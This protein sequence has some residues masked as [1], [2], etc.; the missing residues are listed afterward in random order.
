ME[1]IDM[2]KILIIYDSD[3]GNDLILAEET[4]CIL[5]TLQAEVRI[6]RVS[7]VI[8]V[9][10]Q[11]HE[12]PDS[13]SVIAKEDVMWAEGYILAC[14]IHTGTFLEMEEPHLYKVEFFQLGDNLNGIQPTQG[15]VVRKEKK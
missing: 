6:R 2:A 9:T 7:P 4:K 3:S 10:H 14:P 13:I 15:C 8:S 12:K 1:D 11:G 5:D